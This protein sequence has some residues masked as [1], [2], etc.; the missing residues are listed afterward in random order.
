M[1]RPRDK[2]GAGRLTTGK[3]RGA[4]GYGVLLSQIRLRQGHGAARQ[5]GN[6]CQALLC[7]HTSGD[8]V[9]HIVQHEQWN[10][11][12]YHTGTDS[13]GSDTSHAEQGIK[14][15]AQAGKRQ[16]LH[17]EPDYVPVRHNNLNASRR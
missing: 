3:R 16:P 7:F 10:D 5:T 12:G 2:L 6:G 1:V 4:R 8:K 14:N 9:K 15:A 13:P 11:P 17:D